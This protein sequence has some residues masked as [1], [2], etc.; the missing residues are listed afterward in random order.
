MS[1]GF[2]IKKLREKKKLSQ[3]ELAQI[4]DISQA[5][6]SNIE[7]GQTKMVD[8]LLMNKV[9]E[10]FETDFDYFI[11]RHKEVNNNIEKNEGSVV[12]FNHGTINLFPE[13]IIEQITQLIEENK[14]KDVIIN[15]L[16]KEIKQNTIS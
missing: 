12:G 13:N 2:K 5:K 10:Y 1:V 7:N 8:F 4:L 16:K 9:C 6:L 11:E 3:P 14:Q 15:S